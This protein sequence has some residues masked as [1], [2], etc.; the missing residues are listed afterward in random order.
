M[1]TTLLSIL[2]LTLISCDAS[3]KE[4]IGS[5]WKVTEL[6]NNGTVVKMT[7]DVILTVNSET[8]FLLKLD[9]NNCFG[10]YT[11]TGKSEIKLGELGCTQMCCDSDF[12]SAVV[13][14]LRKVSTI[15]LDKDIVTLSS[16][17]V[18]IKF[19]RYKVLS[20]NELTQK[21]T[22]T[23]YTR[24][25]KIPTEETTNVGMFENPNNAQGSSD[26][27]PK[28]AYIE[29]YKSPCKGTC[30]EFTMKFY[31]D[32]TVYYTGKF[33]AQVQGNHSV[34]ITASKSKSLFNEFEQSNFMGFQ[35]KYDNERIMD[36]QNTY[37]TY[38]GKKIHIRDK[39]AAPKELKVLLEKV[40]AQAKEALDKLKKK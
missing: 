9:K 20:K 6:K 14:A 21:A 4:F 8:R 11:I 23:A 31:A 24:K 22:E 3:T 33:N 18:A 16:D 38:K 12:S 15:N 13:D 36:L 29:L 5:S 30:E 7:N 37:L 19:E 35:G 40:E 26:G 25:E 1:K 2:V 28:G 39:Y 10:S 17:V 32:G 27:V 34:K